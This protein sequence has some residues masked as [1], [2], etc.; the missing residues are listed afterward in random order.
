MTAPA[1]LGRRQWLR[2]QLGL[3]AAVPAWRPGAAVP[4][5]GPG[6]A[7]QAGATLAWRERALLGF[8]TTL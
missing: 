3:A 1:T 4:A 6:A 5:L 2:W 7:S 8:G